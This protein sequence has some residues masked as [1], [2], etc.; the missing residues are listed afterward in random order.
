MIDLTLIDGNPILI[1][2]FFSYFILLQWMRK[3]VSKN[4][5]LKNKMAFEKDSLKTPFFKPLED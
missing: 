2:K 3:F 4:D 5:L 1:A